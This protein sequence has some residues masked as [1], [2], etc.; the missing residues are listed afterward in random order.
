FQ[1]G[2]EVKHLRAAGRAIHCKS[3]QRSLK[4][5][6]FGVL[7]ASLAQARNR[8]KTMSALLR[9]FLCC[10]S[11]FSSSPELCVLCVIK[12]RCALCEQVKVI[13][14]GEYSS[15]FF[16]EKAFSSQ[17]SQRVKMYFIPF[18]PFAEINLCVL[19]VIKILCALCE[20][21]KVIHGG[22]YSSAF[23]S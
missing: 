16:R 2:P 19:C 3:S 9:A 11:R 12:I 1:A 8:S 17:I 6:G 14:R 13:H 7:H 5:Y 22:K 4:T 18:A 20:Q 15:A 21:V 10:P 23:F